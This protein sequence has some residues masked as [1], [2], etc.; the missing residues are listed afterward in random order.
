[1]KP[2]ARRFYKSKAWQDCRASYIASV[3]RLCE[4][5]TAST[6]GKIVHHKIWLTPENINDPEISLNHE[7]LEYVCQ[8][9]HNKEH[10]GSS[11]P[12]RE[13]LGFDAAGNLVE[14]PPID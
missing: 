4:R 6:P 12:V 8:T 7:N 1:M 2:W 11:E 3:Y 5:C 9:C 14:M 13:G 10:H